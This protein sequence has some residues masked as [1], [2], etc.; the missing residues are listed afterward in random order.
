MAVPGAPVAPVDRNTRTFGKPA[1]LT[2]V[3]WMLLAMLLVGAAAIRAL[4]YT[5]FFGSDEVTYV[6]AAMSAV[7]GVW[8]NST[9]IG[10]IR[11]GV[12]LPIA[13]AIA[14]FGPS[15]AAVSSWAFLCS[16]LEVGV[17]YWFGHRAMGRP[18]A[19][20]AS[21]L[22]AVLPLHVHLA[23]RIMADPPLALFITTTFVVLFEAQQRQSN[24]LYLLAGLCAGLTFWIKEAALIFVG[25]PVLWAVL[26]RDALRGWTWFF[27]GLLALVAGNFA[28]MWLLSGDPLHLVGAVGA[29]VG[30]Y[31]TLA[32]QGNADYSRA[33]LYYPDYLFVRIWHTWLLGYFAV[34][35]IAIAALRIRRNAPE[36]TALR[37]LLVWGLGLVAVFSLM[38][39][40]ISPILLIPKQTN[41]MTIF[42]APLSVLAGIGIVALRPV[43]KALGL[44]FF[45][46]GALV[47]CAMEQQTIRTFTANSATTVAFAG[48]HPDATVYVGTNAERLNRWVGLVTDTDVAAVRNLRSMSALFEATKLGPRPSE[49]VSP[50]GNDFAIV[51]GETIGWGNN[52]ISSITQIPP[53]WQKIGTLP[54]RANATAGSVVITSIET[55]LRAIPAAA[56]ASAADKLAGRFTPRPALLYR[57]PASCT[58]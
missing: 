14:I 54:T 8:P 32:A 46:L 1:V 3:D 18:L 51:D 20:V 16:V 34:L 33:A 2:G 30:R 38:I 50:A 58:G 45:L 40:S 53:C 21:L 25:V 10:A 56:G 39:V 15:V 52:G 24:R 36:A 28:A 5:G 7:N 37:Y 17:V 29:S 23:G 27:G 42:L 43:A 49:V 48:Q 13:A 12:N 19:V 31:E 47:L 57:V 55:V 11:L 44:S 9:Y 6:D 41:Y 22:L 35:G 4:F 26:H